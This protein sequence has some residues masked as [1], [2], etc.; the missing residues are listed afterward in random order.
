MPKVAS[1]GS[2]SYNNG[3]MKKS[4]KFIYFDVGGVLLDW[5][6]GFQNASEKY[7]IPESAI[8]K[9]AEKYWDHIGRGGDTEA[10]MAELAGL[11]GLSQPYPDLTD[12]WTD[13]HIPILETHALAVEL[14]KSYRLGLLTNAERGAMQHAA[15]KGLLP[16]VQ[17]DA[18]IDSSVLGVIKPERKIYEIA[19]RMAGVDPEEIFFTDDVKEHVLAAK[20][21]GWQGLVFDTGNVDSSIES[22]RKIVG[23]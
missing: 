22:I 8:Y 12:F 21:R 19:E 1:R 18:V 2:V 15:R 23:R 6:K 5:R 14:K 16:D 7:K 13:H 9:I 17:W 10:Y 20:K 4:I 11:F 3:L